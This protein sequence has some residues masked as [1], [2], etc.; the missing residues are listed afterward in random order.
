MACDLVIELNEFINDKLSSIEI[1]YD[2]NKN[3]DVKNMLTSFKDTLTTILSMVHELDLDSD[4]SDDSSD[5]SLSVNDETEEI[6]DGLLE[7]VE[8]EEI[9]D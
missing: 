7:E 2:G 1:E 5:G 8:Y 6:T 3:I 9:T 4:D